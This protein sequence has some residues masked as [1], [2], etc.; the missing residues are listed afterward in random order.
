MKGFVTLRQAQVL[1]LGEG[2]DDQLIAQLGGRVEQLVGNIDEPR[3]TKGIGL[4]VKFLS[5]SLDGFEDLDVGSDDALH[6]LNVSALAANKVSGNVMQHVFVLS[7]T[8][9]GVGI[10][11]SIALLMDF[12]SYSPMYIMF[13]R[14]PFDLRY[15][16]GVNSPYSDIVIKCRPQVPIRH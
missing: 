16:Y 15:F 10:R 7:E 8:K 9:R 6:E 3:L 12:C 4:F 11:G 1:V 14:M 13:S 5:G 2:I